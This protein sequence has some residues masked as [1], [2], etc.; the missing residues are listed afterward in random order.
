M[1]ICILRYGACSA[2]ARYLRPAHLY[3][4]FQH[5]LINGTIL[6]KQR[7]LNTKCVF[8]FSLQLLSETFLILRGTERDMIKICI[9]VIM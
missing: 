4:I 8:L 7:L 9:L 1:C 3:S 5:Y 6:G 2:H